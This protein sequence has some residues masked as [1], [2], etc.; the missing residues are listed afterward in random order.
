MA[1]YLADG[2]A[3]GTGSQTQRTGRPVP[4]CKPRK[5]GRNVMIIG[6]R[7][8]LV[9][10]TRSGNKEDKSQFDLDGWGRRAAMEPEDSRPV[11]V[12]SSSTAKRAAGLPARS[13]ETDGVCIGDG[14]HPVRGHSEVQ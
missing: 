11:F 3:T 10:A 2:S 6:R 7:G 8:L 1:L 14:S 5:P 4:S 9:P 12:Q 13:A